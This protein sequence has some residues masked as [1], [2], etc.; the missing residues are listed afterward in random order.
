[1]LLLVS[2]CHSGNLINQDSQSLSSDRKQSDPNFPEKEGEIITYTSASDLISVPDSIIYYHQGKQT[3][4]NNDNNKFNTII[5]MTK[6]RAF[7]VK[8]IF[9]TLVTKTD[10]ETL[11][12]N[13][14]VLEFLYSKNIAVNWKNPV[15]SDNVSNYEYNVILF[16]LNGEWNKFM[17]FSPKSSG[18]L[19][20]M[21]SA[22]ELLKYLNQ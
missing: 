18:P 5:T 10:I 20:S 22:D 6:N 21:G 8:G 2:G 16:P 4:I 13:N 19:G 1:M 14:F 12:Q 15:D 7:I 17:I 11:K 3:I 9:K